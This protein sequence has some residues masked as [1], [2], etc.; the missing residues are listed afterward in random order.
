MHYQKQLEKI[1]T[2]ISARA[3]KNESLKKIFGG[4]KDDF[5][6]WL[7]THGY[8]NNAIVRQVFQCFLLTR[9]SMYSARI[10]NDR[11]SR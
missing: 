2:A 11:S 5:W 6:Y 10:P 3:A 7:F 4:I 8:D 9:I 1:A